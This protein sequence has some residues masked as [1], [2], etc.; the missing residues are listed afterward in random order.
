MKYKNFYWYIIN[1][2]WYHHRAMNIFLCMLSR[3]HF[4]NRHIIYRRWVRFFLV[5]IGVPAL[6]WIGI[7]VSWSQIWLGGRTTLNKKCRHR[8]G[9]NSETVTTQHENNQF[10]AWSLRLVF[11][12]AEQTHMN[13]SGGFLPIILITQVSIHQMQCPPCVPVLPCLDNKQATSRSTIRFVW[14]NLCYE[15]I[16]IY[17]LALVGVRVLSAYIA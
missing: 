7:S 12:D 8:R 9:W 5:L 17:I 16:G 15:T 13:A 4:T 6:W 2:T 1:L 11:L 3:F 14:C 10:H